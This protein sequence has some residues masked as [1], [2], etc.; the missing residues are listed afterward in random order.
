MNN[1]L[2]EDQLCFDLRGILLAIGCGVIDA[3]VVIAK[4]AAAMTSFFT[5][6]VLVLLAI[7]AISV[8]TIWQ[9]EMHFP[10][11]P[12]KVEIN[13]KPCGVPV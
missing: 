7:G 2:I 1:R 6:V 9:Y 11:Q 3:V 8:V 5:S 13:S 4:V 10:R 12:I